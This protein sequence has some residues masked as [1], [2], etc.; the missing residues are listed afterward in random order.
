VVPTKHAASPAAAG[1]QNAATTGQHAAA[2]VTPTKHAA[3]PAAAA[4]GAQNAGP[5]APQHAATVV[6]PIRPSCCRC[7]SRCYSCWVW[8][9]HTYILF[10][11]WQQVTDLNPWLCCCCSGRSQG[12]QCL[13]AARCSC[14][15]VSAR[16]H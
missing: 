13:A 15:D 16:T 10:W 11:C 9:L 12:D 7:R 2:A 6:T 3:S 1:A 4:A 8:C 5:A 14:R